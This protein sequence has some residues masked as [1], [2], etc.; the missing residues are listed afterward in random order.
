MAE[1]LADVEYATFKADL[2]LEVDRV[3]AVSEQ[4]AWVMTSVAVGV[5]FLSGIIFAHVLSCAWHRK[6]IG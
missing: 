3:V 5:G 4:L 2:A 1:P 6:R